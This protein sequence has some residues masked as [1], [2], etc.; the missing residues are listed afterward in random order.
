MSIVTGK[1][2]EPSPKG[3]GERSVSRMRGFPGEAPPGGG[4]PRNLP[5]TGN[6]QASEA[7]IRV[8][9][10][11]AAGL[12]GKSRKSG[13]SGEDERLISCMRSFLGVYG[14]AEAGA[15]G[16]SGASGPAVTAERAFT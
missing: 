3:A 8:S 2:R 1:P 13:L 15:A 10:K 7:L 6:P 11:I 12:T 4:E 5:Q 16:A 14:F 9:E